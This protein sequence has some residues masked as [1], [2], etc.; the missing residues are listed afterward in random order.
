MRNIFLIILLYSY[1]GVFGQDPLIEH[2]VNLKVNEIGYFNFK[3]LKPTQALLSTR[4]SEEELLNL[5]SIGKLRNVPIYKVQLVYTRFAEAKS[6]DQKELNRNRLEQLKKYLPKLFET[7]LIQWELI[8]Q[9]GCDNP[10]DCRKFFHGFL[11]SYG[12]PTV[13][14]RTIEK[15]VAYIERIFDTKSKSAKRKR[16]KR[17]KIEWSTICYE[18]TKK[19]IREFRKFLNQRV[20]CIDKDAEL[21]ELLISFDEKNKLTDV[22]VEHIICADTIRKLAI[23]YFKE[24]PIW[25]NSVIEE[26]ASKTFVSL[27][28]T[29]NRGK[30]EFSIDDIF[31]EPIIDPEPEVKK[32]AAVGTKLNLSGISSDTTIFSVFKRNKNWNKMLIVQDVTGSMYPYTAQLL[33]WHYLNLKTS[34]IKSFTF[35]NDGD[36]KPNYLK[37]VGEVGGIHSVNA[38]SF[39]KVKYHMTQTMLK[40]NGGDV[41]ENNLEAILKGIDFCP[42]CDDIILIADNYATPRDMEL[43]EK[44]DKPIH[45]ILCGTSKGVNPRYIDLIKRIGGSLHTARSDVYNLKDVKEKDPIAIDGRIYMISNGLFQMIYDF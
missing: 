4:F 35:F 27:M 22:A 37:T 33:I 19:R 16:R 29:F 38:S 7:N 21:V 44:L 24:H 18:N 34:K 13:A 30:F 9:T 15:E 8:S 25:C 6:F 43:V 10:E 32:I 14:T 23:N 11:V 42:D 36:G 40:G 17:K 28:M 39:E 26:K 41:P 45:L 31:Y 2:I 12:F 3:K 5:R 1:F 20:D